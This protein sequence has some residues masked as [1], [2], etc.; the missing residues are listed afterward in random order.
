MELDVELDPG[1]WERT[2]D[3]WF[4][5]LFSDLRV[6]ERIGESQSSVAWAIDQ[7]ERALDRLHAYTNTLLAELR[8]SAA[9]AKRILVDG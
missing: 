4:D 1:S 3:V 9:S 2:F 6:R 5:N 8:E 7:V